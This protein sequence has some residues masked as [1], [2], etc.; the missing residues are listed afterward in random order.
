MLN[1]AAQRIVVNIFLRCI[2]QSNTINTIFIKKSPS[3]HGEI[4]PILF[5]SVVE[6]KKIC[7][8]FCQIREVRNKRNIT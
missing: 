3:K 4:I 1:V 2:I 7:L 8:F 5:E 6:K